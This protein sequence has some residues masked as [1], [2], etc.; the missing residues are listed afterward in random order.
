M[1]NGWNLLAYPNLHHS[2]YFNRHMSDPAIGQFHDANKTLRIPRIVQIRFVHSS[3]AKLGNANKFLKNITKFSSRVFVQKNLFS[4]F[5]VEY[6]VRMSTSRD[7]QSC[8][9][10]KC[11][12]MTCVSQNASIKPINKVFQ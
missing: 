6:Y 1:K 7:I 12:I 4:N 10:N 3:E 9:P 11:D 5:S 2:S 8:R